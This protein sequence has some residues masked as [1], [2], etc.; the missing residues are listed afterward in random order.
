V[1]P[2]LLSSYSVYQQVHCPN[3]RFW[4]GKTAK[5]EVKYNLVPGPIR[6]TIT[7]ESN[8]VIMTEAGR[9]PLKLKS[10]VVANLKIK[11]VL[12]YY[13]RNFFFS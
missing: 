5:I 4:P 9:V 8:A 7:V 2:P 10:E 6:K 1:T 13:F 3:Q 11:N 12:D